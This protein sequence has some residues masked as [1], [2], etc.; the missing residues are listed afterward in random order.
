MPSLL[1]AT[2]EEL[3]HTVPANIPNRIHNRVKGGYSSY[4]PNI[5][6]TAIIIPLFTDLL[7]SALL[8]VEYS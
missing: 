1:F 6:G 5:I 2:R 8:L 4:Q 3:A 7:T